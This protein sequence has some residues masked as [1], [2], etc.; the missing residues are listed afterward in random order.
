MDADEFR[1][2]IEE[3]MS[4]ELERLGSS[5]LLVAQTN[6][7]L[8]AEAVLGAVADSERNAA[9]TFEAWV[10]DEDHD[11]ARAAFAEYR[12]QERD[13]YDR[14]VA[15]L[16]GE[17]EPDD[18]D[19]DPM[20]DR[21]GTLETTAGRLGGVVGRSLV[22]DRAHLQV[23]SFFVNEGDERRADTVRALR[24]ETAAQGDRGLE[25]L[26]DVCEGR[27]DWDRARTVAEDVIDIAYEA[28]ADSLD[29][30]GLDPKPIC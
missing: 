9:D 27:D 7:N 11:D 1:R 2:T 6:A 20:H 5:K 17:H 16:D 28:Y 26:A 13:H 25:V 12:E 24:S 30:L 21:L 22:A 29:D 15:L 8:T 23:V 10:D 18:A 14:V 19:A 3:S 4:V